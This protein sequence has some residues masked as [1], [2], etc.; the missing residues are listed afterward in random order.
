MVTIENTSF[1]RIEDQSLRP[2][3]Y[4][5][6]GCVIL[7]CCSPVLVPL[8]ANVLLS[9]AC[10]SIALCPGWNHGLAAVQRQ[11]RVSA[12][13][14]HWSYAL[15]P[16]SQLPLST[17]PQA[18]PSQTSS[19]G[20]SG[21]V[22]VVC[23]VLLRGEVTVIAYFVEPCAGMETKQCCWKILVRLKFHLVSQRMCLRVVL[24]GSGQHSWAPYNC[25]VEAP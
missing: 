19:V 15:L 13:G 10:R 5:M 24:S 3:Y 21:S 7:W 12:M 9:P 1:L 16:F 20:L 11:K 23:N 14:E 17:G 25:S 8:P 2:C 4:P 22:S 6:L 18:H